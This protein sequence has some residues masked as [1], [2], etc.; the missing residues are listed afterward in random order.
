MR[1]WNEKTNGGEPHPVWYTPGDAHRHA[2]MTG[3]MFC[4]AVHVALHPPHGSV[5][6]SSHTSG[7][8]AM[9]SPQTAPEQTLA[10]Q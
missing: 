3:A 10:L 9:P 2:C 6:P 7:P 8:H 5:A 1:F 4:V